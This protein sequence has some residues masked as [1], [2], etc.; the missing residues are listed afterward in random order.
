M[1][2]NPT[3]F[4]G[5]LVCWIRKAPLYIYRER[6]YQRKHIFFLLV[7]E[8][9]QNSKTIKYLSDYL[10]VTRTIMT[11][12]TAVTTKVPMPVYTAV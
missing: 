10:T 7:V 5:S 2:Y 8:H 6:Q 9:M 4:T 12:T 11:A 1:L 3:H